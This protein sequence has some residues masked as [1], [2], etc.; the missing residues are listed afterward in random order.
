MSKKVTMGS[1][2]IQ[3]A[4]ESTVEAWVKQGQTESE[5]PMRR[6]TIDVPDTLHR[7]IKSQCALKGVKMAD[8]IRRILAERF[9]EREEA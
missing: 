2:P 3:P 9:P 6:F 8:E 7:R 4:R 1:K 5:E